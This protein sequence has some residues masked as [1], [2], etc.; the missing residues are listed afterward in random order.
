MNVVLT[1][2]LPAGAAFVLGNLFLVGTSFE[3]FGGVVTCFLGDLASG[4]SAMVSIVVTPSLAG[5][6]TNTVAV[7][8]GSQDTNSNT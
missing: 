7:I 4:G 2:A 5:S 6:L 8:T 1:N 3:T